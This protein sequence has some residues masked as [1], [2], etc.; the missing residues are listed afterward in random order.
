M[1]F[2]HSTGLQNVGSYQ[3]SGRPWL[4]SVEFPGAEG[5][6]YEFPNVTDYIKITNDIDSLG[7]NLDIVFCKPRRAIDMHNSSVQN[8]HYL[9]NIAA[10]SAFSVAM[11]VQ[12]D[13]N[14]AVAPTRF[15][16]IQGANLE[17]R[18]QLHNHNSGQYK[19][20]LFEFSPSL[21]V[22]G[23][24]VFF[25]N[26]NAGDW[27]HIVVTVSE[28]GEYTVY[29]DGESKTTFQ[30]PHL[31]QNPPRNFDSIRFGDDNNL[32]FRGLYDEISLFSSDL[33]AT[34]VSE[35]YN[36]GSYY[37][38]RN[39]SGSSTLLSFWDFEDNLYKTFYSTPDTSN[40]I[41]DRVGSTNLTFQGT[42][43]P[44]FNKIPIYFI[45]LFIP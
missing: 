34:E 27:V 33:S 1:S 3:V 17:L 25:A 32:T 9:G 38:I 4:K 43:S 36:N 29:F 7:N 8:D 35:I 41:Q 28:D 19:F 24:G 5:R 26:F 45:T 2:R 20:L 10:T 22:I 6:F 30:Y 42:N 16:S 18:I 14:L 13:P 31:S 12:F 21:Q 39:Y 37:D 40:T 15:V 23:Q 44:S 11:W